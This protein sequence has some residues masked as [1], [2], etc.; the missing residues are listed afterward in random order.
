MRSRSRQRAILLWPLSDR[1]GVS[2]CRKFKALG[3]IGDDVNLKEKVKDT[4]G[5]T[6]GEEELIGIALKAEQF[7]GKTP[8]EERI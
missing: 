1:D 6:N 3:L 8:E 7:E 5:A 2:E 4:D